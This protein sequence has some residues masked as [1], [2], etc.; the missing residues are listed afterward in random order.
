M[1][2]SSL[3]LQIS[4]EG[5]LLC[6]ALKV[7]SSLVGFLIGPLNNLGGHRNDWGTCD[8]KISSNHHPSTTVLDMLVGMRC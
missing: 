7:Y 3:Y 4:A 6:S 5:I 2:H 8:Y 1:G